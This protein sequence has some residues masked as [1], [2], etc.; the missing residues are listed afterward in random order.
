MRRLVLAHP[1][2]W[3]L[4]VCLCAWA[5]LLVKPPGADAPVYCSVRSVDRAAASAGSDLLDWGTMVVAMMVPLMLSQL[6]AVALSSAWRRRHLAIGCYLCGYLAV[7]MALKLGCE[8][9]TSRLAP[10]AHIAAGFFALACAWH[11]A[12]VKRR[13]AVRCH[14]RTP[15]PMAGWRADLVCLRYGMR[16]GVDCLVNCWPLMLA[17]IVLPCNLALMGV[18]MGLI[19]ADRRP[20]SAQPLLLPLLCA[21]VA[22]GCV[23][24]S[25]LNE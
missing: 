5:M 17:M 22:A 13:A 2:L 6:R 14:R 10:A 8:L 21:S 12:P 18:V 19:A 20:R 4:G 25:L 15:L 9:W 24:G 11:F 16:N 7:W 23:L 3:V 1:Q